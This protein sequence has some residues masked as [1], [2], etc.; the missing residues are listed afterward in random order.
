MIVIFNIVLML[1]ACYLVY[2]FAIE[3][4][5]K[6]E[7]I[8]QSKQPEQNIPEHE[9][10]NVYYSKDIQIVS[11]PNYLVPPFRFDDIYLMKV[12]A[13]DNL[14]FVWFFI[15]AN[16]ISIQINDSQLHNEVIRLETA[17][18]KTTPIDLVEDYL[19]GKK[20]LK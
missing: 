4:R 19:F 17:Q 5:P 18:Q 20:I 13:K 3:K 15:Q 9:R 2:V 12:E 11:E 16:L 6:R 14:V 1:V 8:E 7:P 10:P